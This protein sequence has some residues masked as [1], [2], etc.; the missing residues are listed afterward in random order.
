M[1]IKRRQRDAGDDENDHGPAAGPQEQPQRERIS[2]HREASA[3]SRGRVRLNYIDAEFLADAA[4]K[5]LNGIESR[6]KSWS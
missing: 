3:D 5:D 2:A 1:A 6:S 4:D